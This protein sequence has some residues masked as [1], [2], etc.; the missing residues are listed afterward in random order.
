[1]RVHC[2]VLGNQRPMSGQSWLY[3]GLPYGSSVLQRASQ[4]GITVPCPHRCVSAFCCWCQQENKLRH[5]PSDG[6]QKEEQKTRAGRS[7]VLLPGRALERDCRPSR[8]LRNK[9]EIQELRMASWVLGRSACYTLS[10]ITFGCDLWPLQLHIRPTTLSLEQ[11]NQL[12]LE[13]VGSP[14]SNS[15]TSISQRSAI[16]KNAALSFVYLHFT[17]VCT[18]THACF[19]QCMFILAAVVIRG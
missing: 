1:M 16:V 7:S 10:L 11:S 4:T 13:Q 17:F 9:T 5:A 18:R 2:R 15:H 6:K 14:W 19:R 12:S 3:S 8:R